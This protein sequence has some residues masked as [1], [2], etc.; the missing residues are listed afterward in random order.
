MSAPAA[1]RAVA[2]TAALVGSYR[3]DHVVRLAA[4]LFD[5]SLVAVNLVDD[6]CAQPVASIGVGLEPM[7]RSDALCSYAI[8]AD[9]GVAVADLTRDPRYAQNRFVVEAPHLRFYAGEPLHDRDGAAVGTLCIMGDRPRELTSVERHMLRDLADWVE[10][11]LRND[12]E[13]RKAREVQRRLLPRRRPDL[14][15][16]DVAGQCEPAADVG[17][18]Y[19]DWQQLPDGTLQLVLGDVMGKGIEAAVVAAGVRSVF[20]GASRFNPLD[21]TFLRLGAAMDDDLT[22]IGTFVTVFAARL[23]PETGEVEY[24]D[25]GHGLALV[26]PADGEPRQLSS[27]DLPLGVL[28]EDRWQAHTTVLE[29]GDTLLMVSDGILD[30]FETPREAVDAGVRM[31]REV[32]SAQEMA[33]RIAAMGGHTALADDITAVVVRREASR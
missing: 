23:T 19:F 6:V 10:S 24:V 22:E 7:P 2:E 1:V 5:V 30:C 11:D 33:D 15:G 8:D 31:A 18:D 3:F 12:A 4:H 21:A 27:S 14:P 25:A 13:T 29:P 32:G 28:A 17:G 9:E 26:L 20:R 16:Y